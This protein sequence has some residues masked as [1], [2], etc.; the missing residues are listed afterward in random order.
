VL[1][2]TASTAR[3]AAAAGIFIVSLVSLFTVSTIYHQTNWRN[4]EARAFMR[5]LDHASIFLLIAGTYTPVALMG[6]RP[7]LGGR[8]LLAVWCGAGVGIAQSIFWVHAPRFVVAVLAVGVGWTLIPFFAEV[9]HALDAGT[10][11]LLGTGGLAYTAGAVTY[12]TK[13][14]ALLPH[15]FGY[16]EVFHVLTMVGA[17]L[18]LAAVMRLTKAC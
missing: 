13:R 7:E 15:V 4:P 8:M 11:C 3:A 9:R 2:S 14:P 12:T 5:R 10:L 17:G 16:H 6:L 1:V 18:H